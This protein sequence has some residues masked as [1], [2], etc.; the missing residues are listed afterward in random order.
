MDYC[1][2]GSKMFDDSHP[3]D[4]MHNYDTQSVQYHD[5]Q[6]QQNVARRDPCRIKDRPKIPQELWDKLDLAAKLWYCGRDKEDIDKIVT[7]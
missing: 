3:Y 6:I 4:A 7:N 5:V 2:H 1:D